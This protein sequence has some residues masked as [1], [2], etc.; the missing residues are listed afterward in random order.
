MHFY[1]KP[2]YPS[3]QVNRRQGWKLSKDLPY[4]PLNVFD[5]WLGGGGSRGGEEAERC[6]QIGKEN[7]KLDQIHIL[8]CEVE[9]DFLYCLLAFWLDVTFQADTW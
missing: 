7:K 1:V 3:Q 4:L 2:R 6:C 8:L 9:W 5:W